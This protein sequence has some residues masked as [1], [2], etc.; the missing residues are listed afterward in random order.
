MTVPGI[1]ITDR[2]EIM[3]Q[4][5]HDVQSRRNHVQSRRRPRT[6]PEPDDDEKLAKDFDEWLET[7]TETAHDKFAK[8]VAD[9]QQKGWVSTERMRT[10][11]T[12][13]AAQ[14]AQARSVL[15]PTPP[16]A[17]PPKGPK[18]TD[19]SSPGARL[20]DKPRVFASLVLPAEPLSP[21]VS[22]KLNGREF[23]GF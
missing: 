22:G 1:Q 21:T 16:P 4:K 9:T 10:A 20:I 23:R 15:Q 3:M 19:P 14:V 13:A 17:V 8:F 11:H 7:L 18:S 12:A 6:R 5:T 2:I